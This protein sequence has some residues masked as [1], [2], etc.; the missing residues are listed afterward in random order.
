MEQLQDIG[1]KFKCSKASDE[2]IP[3]AGGWYCNGCHKIV[4]DMRGKSESEVKSTLAANNYKMCGMFEADRIRISTPLSKW[5]KWG[6]AALLAFGL[7]GLKQRLFAQQPTEQTAAKAQ[8]TKTL[9]DGTFGVVEI[10][11]SPEFVGGIDNFNKYIANH[12]KPDSSCHVGVKAIATF[13]V[14][15]DGRITNVQMLRSPFSSQMNAQILNMLAHSPKWKPGM[16][17]GKVVRQ[18]YTVPITPVGK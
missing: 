12:L 18:Q 5:R 8:Q 17:A 4:H 3:C 6:T 10:S 2:L 1:L 15:K 9:P 11:A 16:Q 14:E 7:T 13:V